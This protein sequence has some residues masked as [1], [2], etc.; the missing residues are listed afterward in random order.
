MRAKGTHLGPKGARLLVALCR[1]VAQHGNVTPSARAAAAMFR[2]LCGDRDDAVQ[3]IDGVTMFDGRTAQ[4]GLSDAVKA[5]AKR[6][7]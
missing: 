7:Q 4:D 1:Y 6:E 5:L 3:R 2:H